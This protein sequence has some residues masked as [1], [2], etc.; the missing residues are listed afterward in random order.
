MER[1]KAIGLVE[2]VLDR[3]DEGKPT[4]PLSLV[5]EVAV[6]GSFA[7][8]ALQPKDV[9]LLITR[10]HA[11]DRWVSHFVTCLSYGRDPY[12]V[13]RQELVGR[14]RGCQLVFEY[15]DPEE[16][17]PIVLWRAGDS[18][19][20]ARQRLRA[21]PIDPTAGRAP[22]HAMLPAFEGLDEWIPR[23]D[24]EA[25]G[26]ALDKGAINLERL[27]LGEGPVRS[28]IAVEHAEDRWTASS[29]LLRAG[30]AVFRY[31]ESRGISPR[32]GHLHG[33]D[34]DQSV[35][36]YFA[37]F[38]L[39]Y[40]RAIPRCLTEHGGKEWIEV[41]HPTKTRPLECLRIT[42]RDTDVLA[43]LDFG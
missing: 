19:E 27:P 1:E 38:N 42:P 37:G 30:M 40:F 31:W 36:P 4:W 24:R 6:F 14:R 12:S 33:V 2:L 5:R 41:V 29:P 8:G 20:I 17:R 10:D 7:R 28:R 11:D 15:G 23:S 26:D 18:I 9:D 21:I 3:L 34:V 39:R 16:L 22:R 25:L 43:R 32:E 35:T 13:F